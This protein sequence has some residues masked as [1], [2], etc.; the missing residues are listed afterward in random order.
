MHR[1]PRSV[2]QYP[3][4]DYFFLLL[5]SLLIVALSLLF[6][7]HRRGWILASCTSCAWLKSFSSASFLTSLSTPFKQQR[8]QSVLRPWRSDRS[9]CGG[10]SLWTI[11]DCVSSNHCPFSFLLAAASGSIGDGSWQVVLAVL[12][13][14]QFLS[15]LSYSSLSTSRNKQQQRF[16]MPRQRWSVWRV[17][18][19]RCFFS[20]FV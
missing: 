6:D 8:I 13:W 19:W 7:R 10:K 18:S 4:L 15:K 3:L 14:N 11:L 20:F 12:D 17:F 1:Q 2:W 9:V 5:V 16:C